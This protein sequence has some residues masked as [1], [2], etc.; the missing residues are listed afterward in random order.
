MQTNKFKI[1]FFLANLSEI[2][3]IFSGYNEFFKRKII[4]ILLNLSNT[5][6]KNNK[7]GVVKYCVNRNKN[8]FN[9]FIFLKIINI[10]MFYLI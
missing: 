8:K 7:N 1:H 3:F 5:I 9:F 10:I 6:N 4:N 2:K